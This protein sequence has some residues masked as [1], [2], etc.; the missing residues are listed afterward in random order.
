MLVAM[1]QA[2][3]KLFYTVSVPNP[4]LK[5]FHVIV[6]VQG[7]KQEPL[8]FVIP[9]WCPGF[10]FLQSYEKGIENVLARD[11]KGNELP[12][13]YSVEKKREW[14]INKIDAVETILEYDVKC[15]DRGY[16]FFL[17]AMSEKYA[18][19]NGPACF[20]Y[21]DGHKEK[22]AEL[23]VYVPKGWKIATGMEHTDKPNVFK[24]INYDELI[25]SPIEMGDLWIGEFKVGETLFEV[26]IAGTVSESVRNHWMDELKK[27][28]ETAIKMMK[29]APFKRYVYIIHATQPGSLMGFGG[30][31]EHLYSTVLGVS[32]NSRSIAGLAAHE[33]FHAWNVKRIRPAVLGPFDYTGPVPTNNLWFAEGVTEYYANLITARAGL[34]THD[35]LLSN[36]SGEITRLQNNPARARVTLAESSYKVWDGGMS[37]GY[38]G[39][40]YY[41]KGCVVGLLMDLKL[42]AV[43]GNKKSMDDLMRVMMERH[44]FPKP[45][46][47]EDGIL[48]VYSELAGQDM[49]AFY[50]Q[51]VESLEELPY[52]EVL[53]AAG[54]ELVEDGRRRILK[55]IANPTSEQERILNGWLEGKTGS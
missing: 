3:E 31:L 9:A 46:Y 36:L 27:V 14:V 29:G 8:K 43:T 25:D 30:G 7:A 38:R 33:L 16:G 39:L 1:A 11:S 19:I 41:N 42:R 15:L 6:R 47:P 2:Q 45:G 21:L 52:N 28:S 44:N 18:F 51:L 5:K 37:M 32:A 20:M 54:L 55:R 23:T 48:K 34:E 53:Q 49:K 26:S 24:A 50:T 22:P 13:T 10:Y 17:C 4:E 40:D 12:V 35:D